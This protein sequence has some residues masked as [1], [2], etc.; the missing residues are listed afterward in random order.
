MMS[1]MRTWATPVSRIAFFGIRQ[2]QPNIPTTTFRAWASSG[3]RQVVKTQ[4]IVGEL[5]SNVDPASSLQVVNAL[6]KAH[7]HLRC[8]NSRAESRRGH[9]EHCA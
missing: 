3:H 5:D 9:L 7:K 8:F 2:S 6:V 1:L 4:I